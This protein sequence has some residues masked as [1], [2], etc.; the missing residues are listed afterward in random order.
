VRTPDQ[1]SRIGVR[2]YDITDTV[3]SVIFDVSEGV[4][5]LHFCLGRP[6]PLSAYDVEAELVGQ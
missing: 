2:D 5:Q 3:M 1:D 4:I 6:N